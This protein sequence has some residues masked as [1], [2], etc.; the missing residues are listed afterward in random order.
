MNLLERL[1]EKYERDQNLKVVERETIKA[2]AE[3]QAQIHQLHVQLLFARWLGEKLGTMINPALITTRP[4]P[5]NCNH[6]E[7]D[8]WTIRYLDRPTGGVLAC[9]SPV[10]LRRHEANNEFFIEIN[11]PWSATEPD[12]SGSYNG[13]TSLVCHSFWE[14]LSW[15]RK[16]YQTTEEKP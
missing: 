9:E 1:L 4:G 6:L 5:S 15:V 16:T 12:W 7:Q 8:R 3:L 10:Y 2:E 13:Y 14:A 11:V